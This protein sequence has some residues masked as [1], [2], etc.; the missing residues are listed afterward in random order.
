VSWLPA[1]DRGSIPSG[2]AAP[3]DG[4]RTASASRGI[5]TNPARMA[6]DS[7]WFHPIRLMLPASPG[8]MMNMAPDGAMSG[9]SRGGFNDYD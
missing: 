2:P 9:T 8:Q 7:A 5:G 4:T 6:G 1:V 3:V